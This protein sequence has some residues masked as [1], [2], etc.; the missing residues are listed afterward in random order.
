MKRKK[1][2]LK[3][4]CPAHKEYKRGGGVASETVF[5]DHFAEV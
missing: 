5:S 2:K 4:K 3:K 1:Y